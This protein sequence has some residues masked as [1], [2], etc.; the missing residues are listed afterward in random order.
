MVTAFGAVVPPAALP[1]GSTVLVSIGGPLV[2]AVLVAGL[3]VIGAVL[4]QGAV[5]APRERTPALRVG[6]VAPDA[7]PSRDAA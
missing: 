3:V 4:V 1:V 6:T 7:A 2:I 5:C